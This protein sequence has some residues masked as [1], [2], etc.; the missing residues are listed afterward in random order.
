M[1]FLVSI[2]GLKKFNQC[3]QFGACFRKWFSNSDL[4]G[5]T[6]HYPC[7]VCELGLSPNVS[8]RQACLKGFCGPGT[9]VVFLFGED[10][11]GWAKTWLDWR[12]IGTWARSI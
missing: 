8:F 11:D 2:A 5:F 10:N 6:V 3:V 4:Q 9:L 12:G 1:D 7:L